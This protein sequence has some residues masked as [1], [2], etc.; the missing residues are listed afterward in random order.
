MSER[1]SGKVVFFSSQ[2]GYGFLSRDDGGKDVFVHYSAIEGDG[3]KSLNEGDSVTF[4]TPG[5]V[6]EPTGVVV[7]GA[8]TVCGRATGVAWT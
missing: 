7:E 4:E 6:W 8:A 5:V 3:Y 1:I 2:K